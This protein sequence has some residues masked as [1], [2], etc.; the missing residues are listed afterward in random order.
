MVTEYLFDDQKL[1]LHIEQYFKKDNYP[2]NNLTLIHM[3]LERPLTHSQ[4]VACEGGNYI[5][6]YGSIVNVCGKFNGYET[7]K[8]KGT[9]WSHKIVS[10][11]GMTYCDTSLL[12]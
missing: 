5:P 4:M 3:Q 8:F 6:K 1:N 11:C 10:C 2:T 12:C 7:I 9:V